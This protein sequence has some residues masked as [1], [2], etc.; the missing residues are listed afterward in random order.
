MVPLLRGKGSN[1]ENS[2]EG[3]RNKMKRVVGIVVIA[4]FACALFLVPHASAQK[5]EI[6]DA[7]VEPPIGEVGDEFT[8]YVKVKYIG[9][10]AHGVWCNVTLTYGPN[11]DKRDCNGSRN[12]SEYWQLPKRGG[13]KIFPFKNIYLRPLKSCDDEFKNFTEGRG[14]VCKWEE[15]WYDFTVIG[16]EGLYHNTRFPKITLPKPKTKLICPGSVAWCEDFIWTFYVEDKMRGWGTFRILVDNLTVDSEGITFE[17]GGGEYTYKKKIFNESM[18]C[19]NYTVVFN[20]SDRCHDINKSCRGHITQYIPK[21]VGGPY[22]NATEDVF[23]L[24]SEGVNEIDNIKWKDMDEGNFSFSVT[25]E[26]EIE[27]G[28]ATLQVYRIKNNT[29]TNYSLKSDEGEGFPYEYKYYNESIRFDRNDANTTILL[30]LDYSRPNLPSEFWNEWPKV[31]NIT[32][33]PFEIDFKN[34]T[35]KPEEGNWSDEFKYSVLVNASKDLSIDLK[36]FDPCLETWPWRPVEP[37][38][39]YFKNGWKTLNWTI[40]KANPIFSENC[41][42]ESKFYFKYEGGKTQ[43]YSG[44][45]LISPPPEFDN[46]TT[47]PNVTIYCNWSK[48]STPC[49]Y[50]VNVTTEDEYKVRLLVKDPVSNDWIPKRDI[51]EISSKTKNITWTNITPFESLNTDNMTQYINNRTRADFILEYDGL[52]YKEESPFPGLE[53]VAAF[54]EPRIELEPGDEEI[55]YNDTFNYSVNVIGSE[56]L[57]NITLR[58]LCDEE[59]ISENINNATWNYATTGNWTPHTWE[60]QAINT[61]EGVRFDVNV[62]GEK[63]PIKVY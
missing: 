2:K 18:V 14:K 47:N 61:W 31:Y 28:N 56:K 27:K 7:W 12:K 60:C 21:I 63:K 3:G 39:V 62:T 54:K 11:S 48:S 53:L 34:A 35:V 45:V 51:K 32:I 5:F 30:Y 42:G 22:L 43:V 38:E 49:N 1:G 17:P 37:S 25:I 9:E 36:V 13:T 16:A 15:C 55:N 58:Y 4:V 26:D 6:V 40:K 24:L 59:W 8:Y 46:G 41:S 52:R 10:L 20:Y 57:L 23:K 50:S 29:I 19:N 33:I 44:P